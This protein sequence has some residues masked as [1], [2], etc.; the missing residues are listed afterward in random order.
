MGQVGTPNTIVQVLGGTS[1]NDGSGGSYF[2]DENST[3]TADGLKIVQVTGVTTG[4]WMRSKNN[5][6]GTTSVTFSGVTLIT[7]YTLNHLQS[8]TPA[9]IH[10]QATGQGAGSGT[11]WVPQNSITS[12]SFQ[13]VFS[14]IPIIG[15]NNITFNILAIR[16]N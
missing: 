7:T 5:S 14:G 12:T 1:F 10:I 9:Q 4:R 15:T 3:A 13:I 2:W 16:G 8:F 6:Y 11:S